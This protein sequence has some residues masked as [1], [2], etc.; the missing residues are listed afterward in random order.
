MR[1][2]PIQRF[3]SSHAKGYAGSILHHTSPDE[4]FRMNRSRSNHRR[5][6]RING[7]APFFNPR[8]GTAAH[9]VSPRQKSPEFDGTVTPL[10]PPPIYNEI[11]NKKK[12]WD[13]PEVLTDVEGLRRELAMAERSAVAEQE[14]R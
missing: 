5:P 12:H 11:R 7:P 3:G 8:S 14:V 13:T 6:L 2:I 10:A 1:P 4:R 9:R